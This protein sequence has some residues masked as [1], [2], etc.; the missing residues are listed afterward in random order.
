MQCFSLEIE[1]F[2]LALIFGEIL[3]CYSL[4]YAKAK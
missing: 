4:E 1:L 2:S 3:K